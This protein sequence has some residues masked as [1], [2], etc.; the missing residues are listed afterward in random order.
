LGSACAPAAS[1]P[2]KFDRIS[3]LPGL[4]RWMPLPPLPEMTLPAPGP[5]I[6][7]VGENSTVLASTNM[8]SSPLATAV[9]PRAS[10]PM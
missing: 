7:T 5:P 6:D 10:V 8:P 9:E 2:M 4:T 3:V 1:V